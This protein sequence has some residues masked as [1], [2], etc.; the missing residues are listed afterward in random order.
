MH[1]QKAIDASMTTV[2]KA[3]MCVNRT[4]RAA[5]GD[6]HA[7]TMLSPVSVILA[8]VLYCGS[9][10][11]SLIQR[12]LEI[13]Y[14][15][16]VMYRTIIL[17]T[18]IFVFCHQTSAVPIE[19]TVTEHKPCNATSCPS[20]WICADHPRGPRCICPPGKAGPNCEFDNRCLTENPV[21]CVHGLCRITDTGAPRCICR[22]GFYGE[23][24]TVDI[25]ECLDDPCEFHE[26]CLNF[27]G[28]YFCVPRGERQ[29][30]AEPE[31]Q[32][33][34]EEPSEFS[35]EMLNMIFV[36]VMIVFLTTCVIFAIVGTVLVKCYLKRNLFF[37]KRY[38]NRV[39]PQRGDFPHMQQ[40]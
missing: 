9:G 13:G 8:V 35:W 34:A 32:A 23:G 22:P 4:C 24:C 25:D 21:F 19:V 37:P 15:F 12:L 27:E 36:V 39:S 40:F 33:E 14:R 26:I 28:G 10:C 7:K 30:E 2:G 29:A 11:H 18:A 31:P 1:R 6:G 20:N 3:Q 38:S 5:D 16:S 17:I